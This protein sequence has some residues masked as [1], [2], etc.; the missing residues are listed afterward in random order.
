MSRKDTTNLWGSKIGFILATS[1]AAVG[2]GNIQ[3][4]PYVTSQ[5]G[6]GAFVLVYLLCVLFIGLPLILV[7]FSLGRS[8][9]LNPKHAIES[10]CPSGVWKYFGLL[11]ILTAFFILSYY[12]VI[13]GWTFAYALQMLSGSSLTIHDFSANTGYSLLASFLTLLTT[14]FIVSKGLKSGIETCSKVVMPIL[15]LLLIGLSLHSLTY[16]NSIR[17][18]EYFLKPDFSKLNFEAFM[19]ALSQAFF[20]LCVGE[21]VLVTYGS[22][23]DKHDNLVSSALSIAMF[24]T[25][26][27]LLAGFVIF[28][29]VFSFQQTLDQDVGLIFDIMPK[30]FFQIPFGSLVGFSFFSILGFAAITT[31]VALLEIPTN[32]LIKEK[33]CSR[34][35]AVMIV[36]FAAW[37]ISL[38]SALSK[39]SHSFLSQ[40]EISRFKI[41]GFYDLMDFLWGSLGMLVSG[42]GITVFVGWKWG[43][44]AASKELSHG[45]PG[46]KRLI[47]FWGFHIKYVI[48]AIIFLILIHLMMSY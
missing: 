23:A 5:W 43:V 38:P 39:G 19:F 48:P 37:L 2:L 21:A 31:C 9:R 29:A 17:G 36:S 1:G 6:G 8:T 27:A 18:L 22:Y 4:F 3:K 15:V 14:S 16:P 44:H 42:L 24:D 33:T 35:K 13:A 46:F 20:S 10:L 26:I 40:L 32:Y 41:H 11:S 47:K 30:I 7:E 25:L 45:A 34:K 28:P 12:I